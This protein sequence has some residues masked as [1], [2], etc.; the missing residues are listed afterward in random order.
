MV[1]LFDRRES[2]LENRCWPCATFWRNSR[3]DRC[4]PVTI[5]RRATGRRFP[6]ISR[7]RPDRTERTCLRSSCLT[8]AHRRATKWGFDWLVQY[9][10]ARGFAVAAAELPRIIGGYGADWYGRNGFKAW[11]VAIG[12]VNDAGRWLV[13]EGIARPNQLA[14]VGWSYGGYAALQSQVLDPALFKGGGGNRPG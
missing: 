7:C 6:P 11:D 10:T 9:F 5:I 1:Y 8:V 2:R 14:I 12:D 3:W 4:G 13:S